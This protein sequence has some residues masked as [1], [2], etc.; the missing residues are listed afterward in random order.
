LLGFKIVLNHNYVKM[1]TQN[2]WC[3]KTK[4]NDV[5]QQGFQVKVY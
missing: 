4:E 1:T 5:I 3:M 2:I